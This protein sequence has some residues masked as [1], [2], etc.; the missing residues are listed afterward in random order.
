MIIGG[1]LFLC[2]MLSLQAQESKAMVTGKYNDNWI[3]FYDIALEKGLTDIIISKR[4]SYLGFFH[5]QLM[6]Y[7]LLF[8]KQKILLEKVI[9]TYQVFLSMVQIE[10]SEASIVLV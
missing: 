3:F 9:V 2:S 6:N 8:H 5:H 10:F 7:F 4:F 1:F